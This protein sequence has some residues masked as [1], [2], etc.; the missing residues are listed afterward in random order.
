[1]K[2]VLLLLLLLLAVPAAS[3]AQEMREVVYLKD[4][5][6]IKGVVIEQV[7][8]QSLKIQ[9]ADGSVFVYAMSEVERITKEALPSP[10]VRSGVQRGYR[11][12][13]DFTF[14]GGNVGCVELST[15]HGFQFNPH[16]FVGAG[17]GVLTDFDGVAVP[18][19]LAVRTDILE[20]RVTPFI[21]LRIG[22]AV[23]DVLGDYFASTFGCRFACRRKC[24]LHVGVGGTIVDGHGGFHIKAGVDF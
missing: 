1:M 7:P 17:M 15:V 16:L 20:R 8:G 14:V 22:C 9:T 23:V 4:G 2:K 19:F 5:S 11:G 21:D 10:L 18:L 6:V 3:M 24:S 12:F 13:A